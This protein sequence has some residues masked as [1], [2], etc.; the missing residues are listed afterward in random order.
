MPMPNQLPDAV[1]DLLRRPALPEVFDTRPGEDGKPPVPFLPG[2]AVI[3]Q[4]NRIFGHGGWTFTHEEPQPVYDQSDPPKLIGYRCK[5]GLRI[6]D[7][8]Y[9]DVG[10]NAVSYP[11]ANQNQLTAQNI[12]MAYKGSVTD[13][14]TRCFRHLGDQFGNSLYEKPE[15]RARL[16]NRVRDIAKD[17]S[18]LMS[19]YKSREQVPFSRMLKVL[20]DTL[21]SRRQQQGQAAGDPA[22]DNAA[23]D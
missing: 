23:G 18:Q 10:F 11:A 17:E 21:A 6:G 13:A 8:V 14:T 12:E 15:Q 2:H 9:Q 1:T 16:Y 3:T 4:A 5:G 7:T 19:G 22:P 20:Q